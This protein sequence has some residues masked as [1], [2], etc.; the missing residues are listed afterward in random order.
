MRAR[1]LVIL[2][3][4]VLI[5]PLAG[6]QGSE[7]AG[8][9]L[10]GFYWDVPYGWYG[11][12]ADA[13]YK[14]SDI[15]GYSIDYIWFPPASKGMSG[16]IS[17]GY[18]PYDY[19]DLGQYDQ[20]GSVETRFGTFDDLER[21]ID[22]YHS[23]GIGVIGDIVLN[24]RGGGELEYNPNTGSESYT[25]FS[26]VASGKCL[27][28]Y[29]AFHPSSYAQ[30][31]VGTFG[32][33]PDVCHTNDSVMNDLVD[34]GLWLRDVGFDGWRLDYVKG[35][36]PWVAEEFK[37][38]TGDLLC[39]AE[40]W[41]RNVNLIEQW[42]YDAGSGIM[43]FDYPLYYTMRDVCMATDGDI[44]SFI[45]RDA[46]FVAAYPELSMTFAANHDTDEIIDDKMLA[47]GF[48]LTYEG[49]PCI[50]WKDYFDYGLN[51]GGAEE[52]LQEGN[53]IDKLIWVRGAL[54]GGSPEIEVLYSD[55]DLLIYQEIAHKGYVIVL[56]DS[57]EWKGQ[58]VET[59][60]V[61]SNLKCVAWS[62]TADNSKPN[63]KET[64]YNG[65]ADLWAPPRGYAIYTP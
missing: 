16:S 64:D 59:R 21:A 9:M 44:S 17:M 19:Y 45:S 54:G 63:A 52:P 4:L 22:A 27:W 60:F 23:Q 53:G 13:A 41:D 20:K 51:K 56:N 1:I 8:V 5:P 7:K 42:V 35:Y 26:D 14:L 29:D 11:A 6:I 65:N 57:T 33:F 2:A 38:S 18:D 58:Y 10:Q 40:L 49:M 46:S 36:N 32:G 31:D 15:D 50:W 28:N 43:V 48:I 30:N 39:V 3:V 25:D 55:R 62:S 47:Y 37:N 12:L 61:N 34:W 24:H